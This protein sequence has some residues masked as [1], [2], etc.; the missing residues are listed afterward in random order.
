MFVY[1][2]DAC[3]FMKWTP[4]I[5]LLISGIKVNDI[6]QNLLSEFLR[7]IEFVQNCLKWS[8]I[9]LQQLDTNLQMIK[10]YWKNWNKANDNN[11]ISNKGHKVIRFREVL[12]PS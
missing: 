11:R 12:K 7:Y 1:A 9:K 5:P 8:I 4:Q 2:F 3:K 6:I 10:N